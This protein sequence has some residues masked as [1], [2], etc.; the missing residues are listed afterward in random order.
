MPRTQI[1]DRSSMGEETSRQV[2]EGSRKHY[3]EIRPHGSLG[4][5]APSE[6][7]NARQN[8]TT[9]EHLDFLV[10]IGTEMG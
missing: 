5:L 4:S 9:E 6:I 7:A 1:L 2:K 3:N 10:T 8:T